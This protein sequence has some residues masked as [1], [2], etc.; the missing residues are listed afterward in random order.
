MRRCVRD[1]Y[2]RP[3][4]G[5]ANFCP[6]MLD[7]DPAAFQGEL[8][9]AVH[10]LVHALGFSS[11]SWPLF[12]NADGTPATARES[13][14]LPATESVTCVDGST[15]QETAVSPST[16][17]V[18]T[19]ARGTV[20]NKLVT[21]RA[22]AVARDIFGCD[23]LD[24]VELENQPTSVGS[25]R[26]SHLEQRIFMTDFMASTSGKYSV[27]SPLAFAVLEDSGW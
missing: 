15:R 13:D 8:S 17:V 12:R 1:Q 27:Y 4:L 18:E 2:D 9:T 11:G 24:G 6:G 7:T 5:H 23:T 25:C 26:G 20:V 10:E 22:V 19:S 14:G 21:P 16:L 3:I